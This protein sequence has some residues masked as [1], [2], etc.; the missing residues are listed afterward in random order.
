LKIHN[1][2]FS[3][4]SSII[5]VGIIAI[6]AVLSLASIL[7]YSYTSTNITNSAIDEIHLNAQIQ[8]SD[9]SNLVVAK[10]ESVTTNLEVISG[11]NAIENQNLSAVQSLLD[12]AQ[13][14]TSDFTFSY[15]WINKTGISLASS[16]LTNFQIA[17][18]RGEINASQRQFFIQA[19]ETGTTYFS[20]TV[21][22][23]VNGKQYIVIA[24]PLFVNQVNRTHVFN[25]ILTSAIS[26][27]SLGRYVESQVSSHSRSA[28]GLLDPS[29]V[30]LYSSNESAI[31][32]NVFA[33]QFQ[34]ALPTALKTPFDS[35][36]NQ[37]LHGVPG[38]SDFSYNG[39]SGTLAYQPVY[40]SSETNKSNPQE[41][42]V[43]Y[44]SAPD[45]LAATQTSQIT[46]LGEVA[47]ITIGGIVAA[48]L[49]ASITVLRWNKR[50][51]IRV[52]EKTSELVS[53]NE[54]LALA[55]VQLEDQN[56]AQK[57]LINIA[58]HELRTPTQSILVSAEIMQ[59]TLN[60]AEKT[61][62]PTVSSGDRT[63]L[64]QG[65]IPSDIGSL[66]STRPTEL[67][68][69]DLKGLVETTNR[70]AKRLSKLTQNILEVAKIDN[71]ALK[72]E[73]E[74]FDLNET[75]REAIGDC[76]MSSSISGFGNYFS[77]FR[78]VF[79]P[80][81]LTLP[82]TGDKTKVYE[83][84]SNLLRNAVEHSRNKG[85]KIAVKAEKSSGSV[86]VSVKDEGTGIDPEI[87]PRLFNKFVTKMGT[88]LGLYISKG[89]VE[90][91][92]G[93]IWAENNSD[94][95][96]ATFSFSLPQK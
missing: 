11:S 51:D 12:A 76:R 26:L 29:G 47:G 3:K 34:D 19:E 42:A 68:Y 31:G 8:A 14:S 85:E 16:N 95:R 67:S 82:V 89:Y 48:S 92:G 90:A 63:S 53:S 10:L 20:T 54:K 39:S 45:V 69:L 60:S 36:L 55:N 33:S 43:L 56:K 59:D 64:F 84:V 18:Q 62:S 23:V 32:G 71:K 40:V 94:G 81:S 35:M 38:V 65:Q 93:K 17:K 66:D 61:P 21:V 72:L 2:S 77:N 37:S 7:S 52:R 30:I 70:N 73:L 83:V 57:D 87:Q 6:A 91:H 75:I 88:G 28:V 74:T 96:G 22:S 86:V 41:F 80:S 44:V 1:I 25:G 4:R 50:L 49:I 9:M 13:N 58:A 46:F 24:Q 27:T 15:S 78:I 79:D 5:I